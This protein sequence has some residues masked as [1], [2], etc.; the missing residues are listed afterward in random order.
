MRGLD[1]EH[2]EETDEEHTDDQ[3]RYGIGGA[4]DEFSVYGGRG[5]GFAFRERCGSLRS[6]VRGVR[7]TPDPGNR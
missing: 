1:R 4:G 7:L 5:S 2:R 3:L 6:D